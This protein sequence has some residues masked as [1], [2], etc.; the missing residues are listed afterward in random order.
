[1]IKKRKKS[2]GVNTGSIQTPSSD[3]EPRIKTTKRRTTVKM[4]PNESF[5]YYEDDK[6]EPDTTL[7]KEDDGWIIVKP[8]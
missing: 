8:K 5:P 1:M 6:Q 4:R 2:T 7:R 3:N